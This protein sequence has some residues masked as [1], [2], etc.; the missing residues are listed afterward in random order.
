MVESHLALPLEGYRPY[1]LALARARLSPALRAKLGPDDLVQDTLLKAHG[2]RDQFR[3]AGRAQRTA[4]LR[5]ILVNTLSEAAR[6]FAAPGRSLAREQALDEAPG[7]AAAALID[8]G[9]GPPQRAEAAEQV[10]RLADALTQLPADQRAAVEL[11][12]L[13]GVP[14]AEVGRRLGRSPA[15]VSGL[16]RRGLERLRE[17]LGD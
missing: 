7:R 12:H 16:V 2:R 13:Q 15:A 9:P 5:R 8:A 3:G 17:A 4:W 1:L 6:R 14:V 11:R 10:L